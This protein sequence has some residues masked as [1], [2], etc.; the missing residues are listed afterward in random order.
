MALREVSVHRKNVTLN[1]EQSLTTTQQ[2]LCTFPRKPTLGSPR[3]LT[4]LS[5]RY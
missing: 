3:T 4:E 5:C 2:A 1:K